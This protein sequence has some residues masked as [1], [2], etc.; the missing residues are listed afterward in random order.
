[1]A[2]YSLLD[3]ISRSTHTSTQKLYN[4]K[5]AGIRPLKLHLTKELFSLQYNNI[6]QVNTSVMNDIYSIHSSSNELKV[7]KKAKY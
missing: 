1:M 6:K 7:Y 3:N 4:K 2:Q 5:V